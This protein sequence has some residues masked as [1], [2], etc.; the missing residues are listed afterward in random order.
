MVSGLEVIKQY[1]TKISNGFAVLKTLNENKDT[2]TAWDKINDNIRMSD[3]ETL[4]L[5][6]RKQHKPRFDEECSQF[7]GQRKQNTMQLL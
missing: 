4:G 6:G 3:K 5:Y 2:N 7:S 1:Q